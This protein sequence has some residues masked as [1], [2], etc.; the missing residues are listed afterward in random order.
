MG[1][2]LEIVPQDLIAAGAFV[3]WVFPYVVVPA[4][5]L[6]SIAQRRYLRC[7]I[8]SWANSVIDCFTSEGFISPPWLK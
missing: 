8:T 7:G 6:T 5:P 3:D 4:S 1:D 2:A